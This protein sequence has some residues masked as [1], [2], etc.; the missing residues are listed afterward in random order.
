MAFAKNSSRIPYDRLRVDAV[1]A[2]HS[3]YSDVDIKVQDA[4]I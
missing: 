2:I 1:T 4:S 3:R